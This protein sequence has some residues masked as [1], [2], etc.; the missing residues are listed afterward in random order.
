MNIVLA[1]DS[2]KG[3]LT[4]LEATNT[5]KRAIESLGKGDQIIEKPMADGGEGTVDAILSASG[6]KKVPFTC[7]GPLGNEMNTYYAVINHTTA[8]IEIANIAGLTQVDK[9]MRNP[10]HTTTYGLGEAIKDA[11]DRSC[12]KV[13]IGLGGSA[14]NDCGLGMLS[15]LGMKAYDEKGEE[16]GIYGRDLL[17][18]DRVDIDHLDERLKNIQ[19]QVACDVE[20]PLTGENGA[21]TVYGPQ[22]GASAEQVAMFDQAMERF[23]RLVDPDKTVLSLTPGA[24]AAGGLGFAFLALGATLVSGAQL[25]G[26]ITRVE[27]AIQ[28]ADLVITGEGQSDEQTLYGKAPGYIA[29][30]A[31]KHHVP[32]ILISGSLKGNVDPLLE[33]FDGC[34]SIINEPLRI[35]EC[36]VRAEELLYNQTKQIIHL[37]H[38]LTGISTPDAS[39]GA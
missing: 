30:L 7:K 21:S 17:R 37:T 8:V 31:N 13:I 18:V 1:P 20:N 2:F 33:R 5:M 19:I 39:S 24:G 3:S 29:E 4:A 11:L 36:L 32:V 28:Q 16:V 15:A 27:E 35:E 12:T 14:T 25:V 10:L 34:F 38:R 23:S 9:G 22:K 26:E 6:G